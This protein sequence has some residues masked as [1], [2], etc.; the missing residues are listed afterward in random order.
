VHEQ[1]TT[2]VPLLHDK[3]P[4]LLVAKIKFRHG[5][6][7]GRLLVRRLNGPEVLP[8]LPDDRDAPASQ[9]GGGGRFFGAFMSRSRTQ[10]GTR[11]AAILG[12][13]GPG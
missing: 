1:A 4:A 13:E 5:S 2:L 8:A 9:L 7:F 11:R 3:P 6:G 10:D 12:D